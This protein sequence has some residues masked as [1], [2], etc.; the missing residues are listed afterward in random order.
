MNFEVNY[1]FFNDYIDIF[2][3]EGAGEQA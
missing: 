3:S 1:M 2:L